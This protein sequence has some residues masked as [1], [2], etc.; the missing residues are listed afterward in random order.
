MRGS[1][2]LFGAIAVGLVACG[3][4]P[5]PVDGTP[6]A[7]QSAALTAPMQLNT[8]AL[9]ASSRITALDRAVISGGNVGV[10]PGSGDSVSTGFDAHWAQGKSTLASRIVFNARSAAVICSQTL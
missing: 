3:E 8:F 4:T 2:A 5:G 6:V 10:A 1:K 7:Q 9:L